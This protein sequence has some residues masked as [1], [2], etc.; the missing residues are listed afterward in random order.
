MSDKKIV[1]QQ[2]VVDDNYVDMWVWKIVVEDD[3]IKKSGEEKTFAAAYATA[4][5]YYAK[6]R[7]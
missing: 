7:G 3:I 4:K 1:V 2:K 6:M 5:E